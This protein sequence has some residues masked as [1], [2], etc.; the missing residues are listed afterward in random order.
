MSEPLESKWSCEY[1]TYENFPS[2][3]KCTMCRGPKPFVSEDIYQIHGNDERSLSNSNSPGLAASACE[4]KMNRNK[5]SCEICMHINLSKDHMCSECGTQNSL[6][7][8]ALHEYIQPLKISQNSD[9]A[10]SLIQSRTN[11]PPT[12]LTNI[13]N[14]RRTSQKWMCNVSVM[15]RR[16]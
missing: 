8:N 16:I 12:S 10:Q 13:E 2:S 7:A 14:S 3:L 15:C 6:S 4:N 5:W 1:C 9:V 11:S